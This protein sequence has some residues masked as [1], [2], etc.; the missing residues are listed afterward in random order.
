MA[1]SPHPEISK[2]LIGRIPSLANRPLKLNRIPV[3]PI[4][5]IILLVQLDAACLLPNTHGHKYILPYYELELG[6]ALSGQTKARGS[7]AR[8]L[9]SNPENL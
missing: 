8:R 6:L 9:H 1:N 4:Y 3:A 5:A 2:P 7:M